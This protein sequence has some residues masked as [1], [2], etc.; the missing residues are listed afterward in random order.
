MGVT[1]KLTTCKP[2]YAWSLD[3]DS[4]TKGG[5]RRTTDFTHDVPSTGG[6]SSMGVPYFDFI[7][8]K[9]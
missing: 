3:A 8:I 9:A 5:S 2:C 6:P 1:G 7:P 4:G